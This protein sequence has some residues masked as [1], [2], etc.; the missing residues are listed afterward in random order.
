[1]AGKDYG[2]IILP[3][4][5][6]AD[7]PPSQALADNR[8]VKTGWQVLNALRAHDERF[9]AMVNSIALNTSNAD[10]ELGKGTSQ[11]LA[12]NISA[13]TDH[14]DGHE[15]AETAKKDD[16]ASATQM[17]LFSLSEWQE[18][19]YTRIVDKVGT[20]TYWEDW[21]SD[22]SDI[23]ARLI[24]RINAILDAA[25]PALTHRFEDFVQG[26]KDNLNDSI[27]RDDAVSMLAQHLI[28]KPV[29]DA[30]FEGHDFAAH[31][32]VSRVM[33]TMVD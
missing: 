8:R 18:A 13:A 4:A 27:G 24:A 25:D 28:T 23:S 1:S 15:T 21:A 30:L 9:N 6:P 5:V 33:Q 29:F 22:V 2:Y 10:K 26:L 31:N 32:P 14:V 19:I 17:A 12:G 11:L 16:K 3:V 7:T 20:R